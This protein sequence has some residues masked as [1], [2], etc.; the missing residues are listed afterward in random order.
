MLLS[1]ETRGPRPWRPLTHWGAYFPFAIKSIWGSLTQGRFIEGHLSFAAIFPCAAQLRATDA[2]GHPL[3]PCVPGHGGNPS[4]V[5]PPC[6][7]E[8]PAAHLCPHLSFQSVCVVVL[9]AWPEPACTGCP[10]PQGRAHCCAC[11]SHTGI[12]TPPCLQPAPRGITGDGGRARQS[13]LPGTPSKNTGN[14]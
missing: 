14:Y 8:P 11:S 13:G 3:G 9:W 7:P 6:T 12:S 1:A 2:H 10:S 4:L 5:A